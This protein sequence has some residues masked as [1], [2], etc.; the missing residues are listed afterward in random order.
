MGHTVYALS[1]ILTAFLGGLTLG[2]FLGGRWT[3]RHGASL[4]LY[5]AL[6]LAIAATALLVPVLTHALYPLA[7]VIYRDIGDVF[8]AY[9]LLQFVLCGLVVLPPTIFMGTTLPVVTEILVQDR[10]DIGVDARAV[11]QRSRE[12]VGAVRPSPPSSGC[13]RCTSIRRSRASRP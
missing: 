7:G 6:E 13:T 5:A 4:G 10:R 11:L 8:A 12:R 3:E 1:A 2:A 9:N